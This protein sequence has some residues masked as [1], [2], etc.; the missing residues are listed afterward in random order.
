MDNTR[1]PKKVLKEKFHKRTPVGRPW[2]WW[3]D[4]IRGT[5]CCCWM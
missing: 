3:E 2:L 5:P 4:N 1:I